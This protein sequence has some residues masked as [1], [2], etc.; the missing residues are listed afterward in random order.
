MHICVIVGSFPTLSETFILN[1]LTG[2]LEQGHTL[3]I[4][5]GVR[6]DDVIVHE[7][8]IRAG[9]LN[10]VR[11]HNDKPGGKFTRV[12]EFLGRFPA[13]LL[14]APGPVL[15]SLNIFKYGRE[16]A[17][18]D[19]FFKTL[20]FLEA[21]DYDIVFCHFGQ[22]G[23]VG[24]RM[25]ELGALTGKLLTVFHAT[26]ITAFIWREGRSVYKD[27]F[28]KG[29]LFL[30]ISRYARGKLL[31]LGCPDRKI[32]VHRMGVDLSQFRLTS[33]KRFGTVPLKLLSVARL[34][35][36]KGIRFGLEAVAQLVRDGI[37]CE[38]AIIGDGPLRKELEAHARYLNIHD[39]VRFDGWQNSGAV[40]RALKD[41]DIFLAPSVKADNGDE[42]GIPVVLME[43]MASRVPV[44]TTPTGGIRELVAEG[45]TGFLA[46]E[47]SAR[48]L[49]NKLKYLWKDP[50]AAEQASEGG[51]ALI[52]QQYSVEVLN[53]V[54][55]K[56]FMV[57]AY[58]RKT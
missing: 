41:A 49:A 31:E 24:L 46:E 26:D 35:E 48:S 38:Y 18:L 9:L 37:E 8:V 40:R 45:R 55:I 42:E 58:E 51:R 4:F 19:L 10:H 15:R 30:P 27:L 14:R 33:R 29:D 22:N 17:S 21:R 53:Q 34:I 36:K 56:L 2:F 57:V 13:A 52:E 25:K 5:A 39:R 7:D 3:R 50:A 32:H 12:F 1:Q 16:S 11:F 28:E 54:L 47:K 6:S 43:A 20:V 44:V 23:L